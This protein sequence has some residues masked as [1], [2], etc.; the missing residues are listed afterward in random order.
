[1]AARGHDPAAQREPAARGRVRRHADR[2][3]V[4]ARHR[5]PAEET[6]ADAG[7]CNRVGISFF[8]INLKNS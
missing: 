1:M 8:N 2:P 7:V 5:L 3:V 6:A 4:P